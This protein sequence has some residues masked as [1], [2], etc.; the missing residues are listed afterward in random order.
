M[1]YWTHGT[2]RFRDKNRSVNRGLTE[3]TKYST[4]DLRSRNPWVR[5][6]WNTAYKKSYV[7]RGLTTHAKHFD[8]RKSYY[9]PILCFN[10]HCTVSGNFVARIT[11]FFFITFMVIKL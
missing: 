11:F 6:P 10:R 2:Q 8:P 1:T 3:P 9:A 4:H 5:Y 7:L